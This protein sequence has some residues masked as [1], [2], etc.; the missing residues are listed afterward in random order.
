MQRVFDCSVD[1][2]LLAG[3]RQ[4]KLSL[5]RNE[6]VVMPTDTVYGIAADAFSATA[7]T[8]L[9]E[10][11]G[12]DRATPPPVL[13]GDTET[14][15]ALAMQIPELA[16]QLAAAF[17]PGALTMVLKAQP[18]LTWDLGE[19]KGTVALRVPDHKIAQ[20][21]LKETGPLAVSSANAHGQPA[22]ITAE[23]A[24]EYFDEKIP[25]YLDAGAAPKGEASTI[26]DL[27]PAIRGEQVRVLRLGALSLKRLRAVGGDLIPKEA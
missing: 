25:V 24:L 1:V 16:R 13:I 19:T 11:K 4:A 2:D 10:L 17:W 14:M 5:G 23:Q 27:T 22:A 6:L 3:M 9:L 12:R 7:V 26:L 21:L 18:S 15:D 20:A 8:A